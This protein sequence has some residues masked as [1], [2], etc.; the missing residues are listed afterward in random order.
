MISPQRYNVSTASESDS[1]VF[2]LLKDK[3][4]VFVF[5]S[6]YEYLENELSSSINSRNKYKDLYEKTMRENEVLKKEI[7]SLGTHKKQAEF[8]RNKFDKLSKTDPE[9]ITEVDITADPSWCIGVF[10]FHR[11]N[12]RGEISK[13]KHKIFAIKQASLEYN[14]IVEYVVN[15]ANETD[16]IMLE[17]A[18]SKLN[19]LCEKDVK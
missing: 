7:E 16:R 19:K 6:D 14:K 15:K 9:S 3:H 12:E 1:G 10:R 18:S 4:G 17:S 11:N 5:H 2:K 13:L 8:M